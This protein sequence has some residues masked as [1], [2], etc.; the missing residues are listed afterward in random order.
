MRRLRTDDDG[1][2]IVEVIV[3]MVIIAGVMATALAFL[4]SG[5]QTV[6]QGRQRQVATALA[7]EAL[8]RVRALPYDTITVSSTGA[9]P[10][11]TAIFAVPASGTYEFDADLAGHD[12]P[13]LSGT[14]PLILNAVSGRTRDVTEDNVTYRV[15]TYVTKT[16]TEEFNLTAVVVYDSA[17]SRGERITVQRSVV[18][19]PAGCL[20]TAQNPFAA[21]CQA[22]FTANASQALG[23]IS[24]TNAD[25]GTLPIPGLDT[26]AATR[27]AVTLPSN[28]AMVLV[29]QTA[30]GSA[31]ALTSGAGRVSPFSSSSGQVSATVAVDS[32]PSTS[33]SA[34]PKVTST[35]GQTS[36]AQTIHGPA[37]VLRATVSSG[38][39]G[40]ARAAVFATTAECVGTGGGGLATGPAGYL[41]PCASSD[42]TPS[43]TALG[44]T[45]EPDP[46]Y[47]F[48][49][50][51]IPLVRVAPSGSAARAV[52]AQLVA[53]NSGACTGVSSKTTGCALAAATRSLG[54][55]QI[56]LPAGGSAGTVWAAPG[57]DD[58]GLLRLTGFAESVQVEE[59]EGASSRTYSRSGTL[60]VYNGSGYTT[61]IPLTSDATVPIDAVI[62]Y[63]GPSGEVIDA[64]Y[65][66]YVIVNGPDL[67]MEPASRTGNLK[68]D[69]TAQACLSQY[70]GGGAILAT[71][72][73]TFSHG[74]VE[75]TRF[76]MAVD[77]GGLLAQSSY[78]AAVDAP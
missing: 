49:G 30:S 47:G 71:F 5:L 50:V 29:E 15:H 12:I 40:R 28:S 7:T 69:C 21:P 14:E 33:N 53:N 52:A 44:L 6:V 31:G 45:F 78:K 68:T 67:E 65:E 1:F 43:G 75:M 19:S 55:V 37:G 23:A 61:T 2:T 41:R 74:G 10:D 18:F 51:E 24:V 42:M 72:T 36:A 26:D 48:G 9:T 27:L 32:D 22:Y 63:Q 3:A 54:Q 20:S 16:A 38:D 13:G 76:G 70:N 4:V 39:S 73:V 35:P 46:T 11:S 59:G 8:E 25:D 60:A 58:R 57:M 17:V 34:D 66:G 56:G 64:H 62:Q 77:L